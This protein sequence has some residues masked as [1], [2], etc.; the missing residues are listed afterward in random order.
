MKI[1]LKKNYTPWAIRWWKLQDP[2]IISFDAL[3]V[4]DK[5]SQEHSTIAKSCSS[6]AECDKLTNVNNNFQQYS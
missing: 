4:C 6:I 3:A 1:G 5:E 2:V